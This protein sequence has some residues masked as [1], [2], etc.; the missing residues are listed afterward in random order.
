MSTTGVLIIFLAFM[1]G[2]G[3]HSA[4]LMA[5]LLMGFKANSKEIEK[6]SDS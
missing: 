5:T 4:A 6:K 3:A 1:I 2:M